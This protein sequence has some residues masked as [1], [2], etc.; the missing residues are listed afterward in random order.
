MSIDDRFRSRL[1][2]AIASLRYWI[3][4][5]ADSAAITQT[6]AD[7]YWEISIEPHTPGACPFEL[8]LRAD[9]KHDMMI[10]SETYEDEPTEDL[11]LFVPFAQ[12]IANGSV[13]RRIYTARATRTPLAIETIVELA[14][15]TSWQRRR[16][17]ETGLNGDL[18]HDV[19]VRD[20]H[21]LPYRRATR[22]N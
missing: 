8:V 3:P 9:G 12:A 10:A 6:D 20:R 1:Q 19:V 7:D 15:G 5:I 14:D 21:F 16:D 18:P 11:D 4:S 22:T 17:L 2:A 13:I